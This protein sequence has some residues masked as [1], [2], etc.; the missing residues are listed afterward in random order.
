L[1]RGY[2]TTSLGFGPPLTPTIKVLLAANISVFVLQSMLGHT[3]ARVWFDGFFGLVPRKALTGLHVWQFGTYMFLHD[4][5]WHVFWNMFILWMFG[6][7]LDVLWG[8]RG[9]LQYYFVTGAGAGLVYFLLMPLIEPVSA[10]VPLIG[11]SGACFGLLMAYGMLFPER[12][13][14]WMFLIPIKVKWFVLG[15]GLLELMSIWRADSVG[16]L[17]HLGGLLFG[18]LYLRGGKKWLD[19]LL[20]AWRRRRA[21]TRFRVVDDEPDSGPAARKEVDRILEKISREGLDSLTPE[22]Q[23]VLRRASRRH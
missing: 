7:E 23:D 15:I 12:R 14:M 9:F 4:G 1:H 3:E 18:Y 20:R 8:R 19:G 2:R 17:A 10:Y 22:E 5:F 6:S 21:G 16:H 13:V 11:A